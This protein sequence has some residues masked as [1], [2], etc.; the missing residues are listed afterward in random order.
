MAAPKA[1]TFDCYGTIIDWDK[2]VQQQFKKILDKYNITGV[3]PVQLQ[4]TWEGMQWVITHGEYMPYDE[5]IKTAMKW[6]LDD[7]R[8]PATQEDIDAF[9]ASMG[10]WEPFPDAVEAIKELK[11]YCK[12][13]IITQGTEEIAKLTDKNFGFGF[14][15]YFTSDKVNTYKPNFDGFKLSQKELGLTEKEILHAGFGYKYDI[16]PATQLGYQTCWVNRSGE[17]RPADCCET[18]M[19]GDL[20][21]LAAIIKYQAEHDDFYSF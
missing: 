17:P 9:G 11:K 7:F 5:V 13:A 2:G 14:D 19:V 18:Y 3:S 6:T 16:V 10:Y 20:K 12:V 4:V 8:I 21:T 15:G 1:I